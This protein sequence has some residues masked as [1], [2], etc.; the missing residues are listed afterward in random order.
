MIGSKGALKGGERERDARG[1]GRLVLGVEALALH[2]E[3]QPID[4]EVVEQR[5]PLTDGLRIAVAGIVLRIDQRLLR[6]AFDSVAV[7]DDAD[8]ADAVATTVGGLDVDDHEVRLIHASNLGR[9]T[10]S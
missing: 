10:E 3:R 5:R 9:R 2:P 4:P 6:Q 1:H 8:L 7:P